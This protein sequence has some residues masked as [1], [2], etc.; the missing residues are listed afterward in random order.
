MQRTKSGPD[1]VEPCGLDGK[2]QRCAPM[3][4]GAFRQGARQVIGIVDE[5]SAHHRRDDR[6]ATRQAALT[7][8]QQIQSIHV[9][10]RQ[11]HGECTRFQRRATMNPGRVRANP[12]EFALH[13]RYAPAL[14]CGQTAVLRGRRCRKCQAPTLERPLESQVAR[15]FASADSV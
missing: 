14:G 15:L 11:S 8:V 1:Q 4:A 5:S 10:G 2:G 13:K 3:I 9:H 12:V 6:S 7:G